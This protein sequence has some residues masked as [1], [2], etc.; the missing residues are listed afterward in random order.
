MNRSPVHCCAQHDSMPQLRKLKSTGS[1]VTAKSATTPPPSST[2]CA[3]LR[4][5]TRSETKRCLECSLRQ[6]YAGY[7]MLPAAMAPT[8]R[9]FKGLCLA[10]GKRHDAQNQRSSRTHDVEVPRR[11]C[12]ALPN[13]ILI[14]W[15]HRVARIVFT[16][17]VRICTPR[18]AG[19]AHNNTQV[20][21]VR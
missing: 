3:H 11:N 13:D 6:K 4:N 2:W 14:Q 7:I 17:P 12:T 18:T 21:N 19:M 9:F 20:A 15:R 8:M 5:I 16:K 10:Y 1:C